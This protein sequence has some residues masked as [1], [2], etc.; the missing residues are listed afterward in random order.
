MRIVK[1]TDLPQLLLD[2]SLSKEG[3][4]W[5]Y[6]GMDCM[7]PL[8]IEAH[9]D[10]LDTPE[11]RSIY[12]FAL[13][14]QGPALS[15]ELR[16]IKIDPWESNRLKRSLEKRMD[17]LR[18]IINVYARVVWYKD[19]NPLSP[20]QVCEFFYE[21]MSVPP[22]YSYNPTTKKKSQTANEDALKKIRDTQYYAEPV[23]R[24]I[25]RFREL[26]G[27]LKV[28]KSKVD[29]DG[30]MRMSYNVGAAVTGRWSSSKNVWGSGT[31]G[32]NITEDMRSIFI[33]DEGMRL[34]HLDLEQAESRGVAYLSQDLDYIVACESSDLHTTVCKMLWPKL[35]WTG[36]LADDKA[37]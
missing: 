5:C 10:T 33:A 29:L 13:A 23:A 14:Q 2:R 11:S 31:N 19:L 4:L 20:K 28:L 30:R 27:K 26:Q 24:A 1:S 32:Q 12:R 25:L 15:M 16:G 17:R 8:D 3:L 18:H 35:P 9:L 7:I 21:R 37:M 36:I 6:N 34:A 22:I